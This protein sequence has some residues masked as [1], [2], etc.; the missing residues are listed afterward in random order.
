MHKTHTIEAFKMLQCY[1]ICPRTVY[2]KQRFKRIIDQKPVL[3]DEIE[4]DLILLV[5]VLLVNGHG[6]ELAN[7]RSDIPACY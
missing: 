7:I 2:Q 6:L 3:K 4:E 1:K 5:Q